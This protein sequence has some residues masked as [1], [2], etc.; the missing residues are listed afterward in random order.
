MR[1]SFLGF[2]PFLGLIGVAACSGH[3][4]GDRVPE[5]DV[6]TPSATN[7][8]GDKH[9]S[10]AT[11]QPAT[12]G[13]RDTSVCA[14]PQT[15]ADEPT[16]DGA[17]VWAQVTV[18]TK[19][20][21]LGVTNTPRIALYQDGTLRRSAPIRNAMFLFMPPRALLVATVD[22]VTTTRLDAEVQYVTDS[23]MLGFFNPSESVAPGSD[24]VDVIDLRGRTA[25]F[26]GL[27]DARPTCAPSTL[28]QLD[29]DLAA[30]ASA[31]E[32]KW[33]AATTGSVSLGPEATVTGNFPL[34]DAR[35]VE[36]ISKFSRAEWATVGK[37]GLYRLASG[38]LVQ[39]NSATD[40]GQGDITVQMT[41][42]STITLGDDVAPLRAELV[43]NKDRYADSKGTWLGV[44]LGQDRFPA[45]KNRDLALVP[46]SGD[47]PASLRWLLVLEHLDLRDDGAI[48][49]P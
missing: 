24:S 9:P 23:D 41:H 28:A 43:D 29:L 4:V 37:V 5:G 38:D 20:S 45:F 39:V 25:C 40:F 8:P 34:P 6:A 21:L 7:A 17:F 22:P 16:H 10:T 19:A 12:C 15:A 47:A 11:P 33:R 1:A 44:E 2:L 18:A 14:L 27:I 36:G 31:A 26:H 49:L 32:D 46:A 48:T 42:L 3:A 13:T 30:L 35:A